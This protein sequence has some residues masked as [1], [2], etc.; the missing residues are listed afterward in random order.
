M[1][2]TGDLVGELEVAEVLVNRVL[3]FRAFAVRPPIV[4]AEDDV[5]VMGHH[6]V[7]E[8]SSTTPSIANDLGMRSTVHVDNCR[9]LLLGIEMRRFDHRTLKL[10]P[11]P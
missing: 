7:P 4:Q 5:A 10:E 2:D 6:G 9:I 8:V 11:V 3:P 1:L